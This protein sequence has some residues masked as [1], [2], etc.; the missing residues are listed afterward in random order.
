MPVPSAVR[1]ATAGTLIAIVLVVAFLPGKQTSNNS[2]LTSGGN[3]AESANGAAGTGTQ[4][5]GTG[6]VTVQGKGGNFSFGVG[7]RIAGGGDIFGGVNYPN[8]EPEPWLAR[9]PANPAHAS[10]AAAATSARAP[11]SANASSSTA[12]IRSSLVGKCR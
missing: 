1:Y 7:V 9:N 3:S 2:A 4:A 11:I 6:T 5:T 8:T 10:S 12:S